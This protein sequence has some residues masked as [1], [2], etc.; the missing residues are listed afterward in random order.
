MA[1]VSE[2][3]PGFVLATG[4]PAALTAG[5]EIAN[6]LGAELRVEAISPTVEWI[7]SLAALA[8]RVAYLHRSD[9]RVHARLRAAAPTCEIGGG[10]FADFVMVNRHGVHE[11]AKRLTFALCPTVH[12]RDDRMLIE[13]LDALPD[14]FAAARRRAGARPIDVG[15][16]S[17]RRR[18]HPLTARPVIL[19]RDADGRPADVDRRQGELIAAAWLATLVAIAASSGIA[20]VCTFDIAGARGLVGATERFPLPESMEPGIA[21]PAHAVLAAFG[22]RPAHPRGSTRLIRS[23]ARHSPSTARNSGSWT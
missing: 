21:T 15:P 6:R 7:D 9:A 16:C 22:K 20:S 18:L 2:L 12:A 17:L 10:T 5:A 1:R 13:T 19:P 23:P 14:V 11:D 3:A 8:P 4:S